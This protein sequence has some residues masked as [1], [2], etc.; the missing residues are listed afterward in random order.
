MASRYWAQFPGICKVGGLWIA[1]NLYLWAIC[2]IIRYVKILVP[3]GFELPGNEVNNVGAKVR[4][5]TLAHL[6]NRWALK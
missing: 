1:K 6:Y 4:K 3:V 2:K 5:P